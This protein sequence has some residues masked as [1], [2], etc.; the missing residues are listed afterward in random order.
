MTATR[1][2]YYQVAMDI[3]DRIGD[4][5]YRPGSRLP[6]ELELMEEFGVSRVTVRKALKELCE[7]GVVEHRIKRGH[8]VT[9]MRDANQ[10]GRRSLYQATI[11]AGRVPSSK[12]L[13][14]R[15][16][17]ASGR[18]AALFGLREG[19]DLIEIR[20]LRYADGIVFAL[21]RILLPTDLFSDISPW[22]MVGTSL[23][24]LMRDRYGVNIKSSTQLLCAIQPTKEECALLELD[25]KM[26]VLKV[27]ANSYDKD[28]RV[29]KRSEIIYNTQ[30]MSYTFKWGA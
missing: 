18:K 24:T 17:P 5:A 3:R 11:D 9:K 30:V 25:G 13:S 23:I 4:G 14:A 12:I 15:S 6:T 8:F 7:T 26:P 27:R 21:E 29:V 1:P 16:I 19:D 22:E 20:R 28:S 2:L 10:E